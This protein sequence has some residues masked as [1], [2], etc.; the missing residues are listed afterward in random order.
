MEREDNDTVNLVYDLQL[1]GH[2]LLNSGNFRAAEVNFREA[3]LLSKNLTPEFTA[4]SK[5]LI[6]DVKYKCGE[7]DSA[8]IYLKGTKELVDSV[9]YN[10]VL[11]SG[12]RFYHKAGIIDTAYQWAYE[13]INRDDPTNKIIAYEVLCS[14]ELR[15]YI[16][17]DSIIRDI[18]LMA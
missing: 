12:I 18:Q 14:R 6:G 8:L 11:A 17:N 10:S 2:S 4:V 3:L 5:M 7:I 1:L 15:E 9:S 16:N 13:M